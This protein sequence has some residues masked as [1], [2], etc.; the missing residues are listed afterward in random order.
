MTDRDSTHRASV[1]AGR[2]ASGGL[3]FDRRRARRAAVSGGQGTDDGEV[4][5]SRETGGLTALVRRPMRPAAALF[6]LSLLF[7]SVC[8][9]PLAY[10]LTPEETKTVKAEYSRIDSQRV[11]V[12]V[13]ADQSVLDEDPRVRERIGKAVAFYLR[14]NLPHA[15]VIE[16]EKVA[17]LQE[18]SG[19]DWEVMSPKAICKRLKS[20]LIMRI[21]L[22]DYTTRA[23]DTHELRRGRIRATL[24]LYDGRPDAVR[25]SLYETEVLAT[26][27]PQSAHGVADMDDGDLLHETVEHFAQLTARKFYDHE[28]SLRGPS[29]R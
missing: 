20:D 23:S 10:F 26:Y 14:K 13:W 1:H 17:E 2:R 27:P 24:N 4:F 18:R 6:G 3:P 29:D 28:E 21:D 22:L 12:V 16:P 19:L 15:D 8:G 9:C 11:A 25:E 7:S 5:R